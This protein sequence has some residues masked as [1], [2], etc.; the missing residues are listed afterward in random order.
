MVSLKGH[1]LGAPAWIELMTSIDN[2][3]TD[4][5]GRLFGWRYQRWPT[6][7]SH[8]VMCALGTR[9]AA[10]MDQPVGRHHGVPP[11]WL[12][13]FA[14][15]DVDGAAERTASLGGTVLVAPTDVASGGR[16]MIAR[17]FAGAPFALWQAKGHIGADVLGEPG[18]LCRTELVTPDVAASKAFYTAVLSGEGSP[19]PT[20]GQ[21]PPTIGISRG[22]SSA[23]PSRWI[24]FI[25]V[26]DMTSATKNAGL[27]KAHLTTHEFGGVA[28]G[29]GIVSK[30]PNG[31]E[32]GLFDCAS[33]RSQL[34]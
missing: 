16:Y 10:G 30:D 2:A 12:V 1:P 6:P 3:T 28:G 4:F 33:F 11:G 25:G 22:G 19:L 34:P 7:T 29:A 23:G 32:V 14:S 17:D 8:Y 18:A 20:A 26:K 9:V 27:P 31:L 21:A 24:V 5:Y 15:D 13:Y